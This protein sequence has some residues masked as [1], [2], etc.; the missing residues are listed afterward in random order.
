M[1]EE[2]SGR[3][4]PQAAWHTQ[5]QTWD[6]I[7]KK[8][9][10]DDQCPGLSP[11][12]HRCIMAQMHPPSPHQHTRTHIKT[13]LFSALSAVPDFNL[14]VG[15][16][17]SICKWFFCL[18]GLQNDH[19][20]RWVWGKIFS[21]RFN[22]Y[23]IQSHILLRESFM[24]IHRFKRHVWIC[25]YTRRKNIMETPIKLLN[26]ACFGLIWELRGWTSVAMMVMIP[27]IFQ[28]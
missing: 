4:T 18:G 11:H 15:S 26:K 28:H 17:V 27:A 8:M 22:D 12:L 24:D 2:R 20:Q 21:T 7:S 16:L 1:V 5:W 13:F 6:A 25:K 14:E 10:C 23:K 19:L 3:E 9:Q